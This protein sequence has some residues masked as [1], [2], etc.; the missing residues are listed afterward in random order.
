MIEISAVAS[1]TTN[2]T[3]AGGV[4]SGAIDH[5]YYPHGKSEADGAGSMTLSFDDFLDMIN[6]LQH[7]PL[8]SSIYRGIVG[9]SINPVSRIVGDAVYGGVF[10]L[11]SAGVTTLGAIGDEFVAANNGGT[12]ASGTLI[13]ALFGTDPLSDNQGTQLADSTKTAAPSSQLAGGPGLLQTPALQSPILQYPDLTTAS[14]AAPASV[15]SN[16]IMPPTPAPSSLASLSGTIP[17]AESTPSKGLPIDRTKLAYG[18]VM[19]SSMVESAQQNQTLALAMAGKDGI[20]QAQRAMRS[21]RFA[22]TNTATAPNA[23]PSLPVTTQVPAEPTTQAAMQ[24]LINE[25]QAMKGLNQYKN[26]AQSTPV[27]GS[28]LDITN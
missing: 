5:S 19:D 2:L 20:M 27:P 15:A 10:G 14:V 18:G 26:A 17:L 12:T 4:S 13:S 21:G 9:D 23:A 1:D 7:I 3:T 16:T 24:N 22:T 8:V 25:L 6:P 11:A 28:A